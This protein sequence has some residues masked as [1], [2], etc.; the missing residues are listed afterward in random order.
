[1]TED[2]YKAKVVAERLVN[3][4]VRYV[5]VF[6][7]EI[8]RNA[9]SRSRPLP[10]MKWFSICPVDDAAKLLGGINGDSESEAYK[11]LRIFHCKGYF[12]IPKY[13]RRRIPDL[14]REVLGGGQ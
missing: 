10:L 4:T 13:I 1:M 5:E 3:G 12:S 14:I 6:R 8:T 2:E 11:L 9:I 7:E